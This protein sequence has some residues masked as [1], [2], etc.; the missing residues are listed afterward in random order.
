MEFKML[1]HK[2]VH[3]QYMLYRIESITRHTL[4]K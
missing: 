1:T 4:L 3:V 2:N